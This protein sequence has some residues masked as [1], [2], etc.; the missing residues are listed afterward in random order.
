[1]R[2]G[3]GVV[4]WGGAR[5]DGEGLSETGRG[6]VRQ[7]VAGPDGEGL[8]ET[9]R[10]SQGGVGVRA[11]TSEPAPLDLALTPSVICPGEGARQ[12]RG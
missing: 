2:C 10:E 6:S 8:S 3:R 5:P 7:G 1:M 9:G 11:V 12:R 4:R